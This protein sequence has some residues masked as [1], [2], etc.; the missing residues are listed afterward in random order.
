MKRCSGCGET[1]NA[2][3]F[4]RDV[5]KK[6]GLSSGCKECVKA[7]SKAYYL[8]NKD[9]CGERHKEW[10]KTNKDKVKPYKARYRAKNREKLREDERRRRIDNPEYFINWRKEN[11]A[12]VN[13]YKKNRRLTDINYKLRCYMRSRVSSVVS[14][15]LRG[16]SAIKD[17][18]CSVE[19]LKAHLE[20]QF[21]PGMSWENYGA[22]H[23]DHIKP[24]ARFDLTD[25]GQFLKACNYTNLQPLWAAEN[26]SKGAKISKEFNNA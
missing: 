3:E 15:S 19:E 16:G 9:E 14:G 2:A 4:Y 6:D 10:A 24:L 5:S 8:A 13:E 12:R 11:K 23:I 1:K 17:L 25:R 20:S 26:I 7:R 22:W 18:G 21:K